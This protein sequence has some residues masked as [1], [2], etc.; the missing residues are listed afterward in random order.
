M[1]KLRLP[2]LG[3]LLFLLLLNWGW[4]HRPWKETVF[5]GY[6]EGEYIHVASPIAG[7]LEK[8]AV[9]RGESV[10]PGQLLFELEKNPEQ[11]QQAEAKARTLFAEK[12]VNRSRDLIPSRSISAQDLDR[13]ESEFSTATEALAQIQWKLDQKKQP[14]KESAFVQDTYYVQGEWV[15]EGRPVLSLL[16]PG[17]IKIRFFVDAATRAQ[18][19][20]GQPLRLKIFGGDQNLSASISYLSS[21]AEYT[22]PVIYSND[23]REKLTFLIEAKP[24]PSALPQL[25]PG[26]P[27]EVVL[28]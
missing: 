20:A 1:K 24:D 25:H 14:A 15:N 19:Q 8:L 22:P 11:E 12:N 13:A 28:K 16:P 18:L 21:Q 6:V 27:V 7:R 5:Q 10:T 9:H 2:V 3:T 23:T 4:D 17:N 26:Q